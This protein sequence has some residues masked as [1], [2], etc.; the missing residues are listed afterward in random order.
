[1]SAIHPIFYKF[2]WTH[3]KPCCCCQLSWQLCSWALTSSLEFLPD[4]SHKEISPILNERKVNVL[5]N[6]QCQLRWSIS[7]VRPSIRDYHICVDETDG[8]SACYVSAAL[9]TQLRTRWWSFE[10]ILLQGDSGS[11]LQCYL[12]LL[13][14]W[15]FA[16]VS[17]WGSGACRDFPSVYMR[18]SSYN[19]WINEVI[20]EWHWNCYCILCT[21]FD[22]RS[23]AFEFQTTAL[24]SQDIL[25]I[26]PREI[27]ENSK[28]SLL[29]AKK[30]GKMY[31]AKFL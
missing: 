16:G 6:E 26:W 28:I 21:C 7:P 17:S 13:G 22:I 3:G 14:K 12:P 4:Y 20:T 15:A 10:L 18:V 9:Y 8:S 11:P 5:R 27:S 2:D 31:S 30:C 19:T 23:T 1:M 25:N 24:I 29:F